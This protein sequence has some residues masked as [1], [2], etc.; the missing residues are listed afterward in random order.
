LIIGA[1]NTAA[2]MWSVVLRASRR[3]SGVVMAGKLGRAG[4][5]VQ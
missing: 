5:Q 2:A 1:D 3:E 4:T